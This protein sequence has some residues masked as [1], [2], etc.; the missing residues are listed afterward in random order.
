MQSFIP[1]KVLIVQTAFIG[2]VVL[3]TGLIESVKQKWPRALLDFVAI[4]STTNL[5]EKNPHLRRIIVFDKRGR[6]RRIYPFWRLVRQLR[7]ESYDLALV[8]HRSFRSAGLVWLARARHRVGFDR[9]AAPWFFH[10]RLAY[11]QA[12]EIERNLDLLLPFGGG[13]A[14]PPRIY[15]GPE[16]AAR[17]DEVLNDREKAAA[18]FVALAPGSAWYTKRWPREHFVELAIRLI[19]QLG[20]TVVLIGGQADALLCEQIRHAAGTGCCSVAGRLT[21]RQTAALLHRCETLV[22][23]DSAPTHLG[24]AA[25]CRVIALF[26]STAPAFG[27][28]PYDPQK[29]R[30]AVIEEPMACRPC[31]DHGRQRC[32]LGS[33]DCLRLITPERVLARIANMR[34]EPVTADGADLAH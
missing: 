33:L 8:P 13:Q 9:S 5:L 17:V 29:E 24:V 23:N 25:Q 15:W 16:D 14:L 12:H 7:A 27:F 31:T 11:R 6:H 34:K 28:A 19:R 21:L 22:S 18:P 20:C 1:K 32:P 4:P 26:G 30:H 2:D 10:Q 3:A